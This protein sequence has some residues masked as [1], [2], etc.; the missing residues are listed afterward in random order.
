[1]FQDAAGIEIADLPRRY[2]PTRVGRAIDPSNS[3]AL[4]DKLTR[5]LPDGRWEEIAS[6]SLTAPTGLAIGTD[7]NI[8]V[9]VSGVLGATGQVWKLT[10]LTS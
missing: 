6:K 10:A 9:A 3:A 5:I 2:S 8:Y 7:G 1:L 4:D